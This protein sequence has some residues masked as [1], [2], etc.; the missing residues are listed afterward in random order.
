MFIPFTN[1]IPPYLALI[2][3]L[4]DQQL[5]RI[6]LSAQW[7]LQTDSDEVLYGKAGGLYALLL[8]NTTLPAAIPDSVIVSVTGSIIADGRD[9]VTRGPGKGRFPTNILMYKWHSEYLGAAH[10]VAGMVRCKRNIF[11]AV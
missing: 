11:S 9:Y 6:Q 7:C 3:G 2:A 4:Y 8:L 1:R 5:A 10:G